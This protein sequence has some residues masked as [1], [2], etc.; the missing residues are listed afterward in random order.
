[1][2]HAEE[3]INNSRKLSSLED[4]LIMKEDK[5][6]QYLFHGFRP[7]ILKSIKDAYD[8]MAI[9]FFRERFQY[10]LNSHLADLK[11]LINFMDDFNE[12]KADEI[13]LDAFKTIKRLLKLSDYSNTKRFN[14]KTLDKSIF[15]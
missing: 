13:R 12:N 6:F 3:Y 4:F 15:E 10:Y 9:G 7:L 2:V 11:V 5:Y 1:M 14:D 8:K